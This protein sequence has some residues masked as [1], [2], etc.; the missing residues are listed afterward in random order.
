MGAVH[1]RRTSTGGADDDGAESSGGDGGG[2]TT[3]RFGEGRYQ[4]ICRGFTVCWNSPQ[5][6]YFEDEY[7][8][9]YDAANLQLPCDGSDDGR[10]MQAEMMCLQAAGG[11]P[12]TGN[13]AAPVTCTLLLD[14]LGIGDGSARRVAAAAGAVRWRAM[15]AATLAR[16][17]EG[18]DELDAAA[19]LAR[20]AESGEDRARHRD[21]VLAAL[22]GLRRLAPGDP[23]V[24]AWHGRWL[25]RAG[26]LRGA[27]AVYAASADPGL[28]LR[29]VACLRALGEAAAATAGLH[30]LVAA[31]PADPRAHWQL[32]ALALDRDGDPQAAWD[33]LAEYLAAHPVR[34]AA[35]LA[36]KLPALL[37]LGECGAAVGRDAR[38]RTAARLRG[39]DAEVLAACAHLRADGGKRLRE[40][41]RG[42]P[43]HPSGHY[44]LA[45][46][47]ARR[48]EVDA[49]AAAL[50]VAAQGDEGL[51]WRMRGDPA[52]AAMAEAVA[53]VDPDPEQRCEPWVGEAGPAVRA[54]SAYLPVRT[55]HEEA[56]RRAWWPL[57]TRVRGLMTLTTAEG[58]DE[59]LAPG[60]LYLRVHR[61][62]DRTY[63]GYGPVHRALRALAPS[64][65][66]CRMFLKELHAAWIDELAVVDGQLRVRRDELADD[67]PEARN[68]YFLARAEA[69]PGDATLRGLAA[70]VLT[71]TG[72][73]WT[74]QFVRYAR[75]GE[76]QAGPPA[77][78]GSR[79][80]GP[81]ADASGPAA[82]DPDASRPQAAREATARRWLAAAVRLDPAYGEAWYELGRLERARGDLAAAREA[83]ARAV[84][85]ARPRAAWRVELA[86]LLQAA[87]E[88]VAALEQLRAAEG[89]AD[90]PI[91]LHHRIALN[92]QELR[93]HDEAIAAYE[94]SIAA[95]P[96]RS[97]GSK[98][99]LG[100]TFATLRRWRDALRC[101][102]L[103]IAEAPDLALAW[104]GRGQA[105]R[106]LGRADEAG[107]ALERALELDR[108]QWN[109][110][111]ELARLHFAD[112]ERAVALCDEALRR[113]PD[114]VHAWSTRG[115]ALH[116]LGRRAEAHACFDRAIALD[117]GY[118]HPWYC[119]ACAHARQ[120]E[121]DAA[122]A[123]VARTL[124]LDASLRETLRREPDLAALRDDPRFAAL[125]T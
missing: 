97:A 70:A 124:E 32:A 84:A 44:A 34:D 102:D 42:D 61:P 67:G 116:N 71:G 123:A 76:P 21:E 74:G 110:W 52:F 83:F 23:T 72:E 80:S 65:A 19:W 55:G 50:T 14:D 10:S 47:L 37:L 25:E 33:R 98:L 53:E 86:G 117:P 78:E 13:I 103:A 45:A 39:S 20:E 91:D 107:A 100:N 114:S 69:A 17:H 99:N 62:A 11:W 54:A 46:E 119:R 73:Y 81:T 92:L 104:G 109:F 112:G 29:R 94:R 77:G 15:D 40:A 68:A 18:L 93:R 6:V 24:A 120:G 43:Y 58:A 2:S 27:A 16:L 85:G 122:L 35:D 82:P 106:N 57:S 66:P 49:A 36:A 96:R 95:S 108:G 26:D 5:R 90:A 28:L 8:G 22:D 48:G 38:G 88:R 31:A 1:G 87:G 75:D 121:R 7:L 30:A 115:S 51:A 63:A 101:Y 9:V 79:A 89:L 3:R 64:L 12:E 113:N 105:L 56:A 118:W 4:Y 125:V 60:R 41:L 111:L 59:S